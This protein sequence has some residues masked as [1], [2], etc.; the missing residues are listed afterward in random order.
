MK[1][2]AN[3]NWVRTWRGQAPIGTTMVHSQ[4]RTH[5]F[6][7][8]EHEEFTLGFIEQGVQAYSV[9]GKK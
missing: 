8:H 6:P 1:Y 4:Y 3:P 9:E 7:P 2:S 5:S